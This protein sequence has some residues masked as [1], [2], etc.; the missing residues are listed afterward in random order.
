MSG[1]HEFLGGVT[2]TRRMRERLSLDTITLPQ[3]LKTA[4]YAT[5][6]FGKWHLGNE[7]PYRPEN[8]GFDECWIHE[9]GPRMAANISHNGTSQKM[10]GTYATDLFFQKATEWMD[11]Q[12]QAKTPFFVYLPPKSP[13]ALS[14]RIRVICRMKTIKS[15]SVPI[16]K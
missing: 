3:A 5:G 16:R 8:R 13:T 10:A 6:F 7:G 4:G 11:V 1:R 12:R 14:K 9:S 2:D 15:F